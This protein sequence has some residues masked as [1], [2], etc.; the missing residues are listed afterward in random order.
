MQHYPWVSTGSKE[1]SRTQAAAL[2]TQHKDF[3]VPLYRDIPVGTFYANW[4]STK[5]A[6]YDFEGFTKD[7]IL[8]IRES[9]KD[10]A[11]WWTEYIVGLT[12]R[13]QQESANW[14]KTSEGVG[15]AP[16]GGP[17][18]DARI[19]RIPPAQREIMEVTGLKTN[20]SG[21]LRAEFNWKWVPTGQ[22]R[23]VPSQEIPSEVKSG[24]ALF[25]LYD[26]G[27]TIQAVSVEP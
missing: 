27:W 14:I 21:E 12:P 9:G 4:E 10:Y 13:G 8:T 17:A 11:V 24:E 25:Q 20:P 26:D 3:R 23:T 5:K 19:F 18:S 16:V 2:I 15:D 6:P 1:L 22:A 7:G